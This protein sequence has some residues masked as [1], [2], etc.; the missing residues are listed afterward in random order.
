M[1]ASTEETLPHE[2]RP[3]IFYTCLEKERFLIDFEE[4]DFD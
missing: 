1:G 3:A 4:L 2:G